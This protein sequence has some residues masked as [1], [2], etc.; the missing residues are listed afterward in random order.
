MYSGARG[1]SVGAG[2]S[3]GRVGQYHRGRG[4][5]RRDG[6][7]AGCDPVRVAVHPDVPAALR[8]RARRRERRAIR[9]ARAAVLG[10]LQVLLTR[11]L[12]RW[13]FLLL[14]SATLLGALPPPT[15]VLF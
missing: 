6:R 14:F 7:G 11:A 12:N 4:T 2:T 15:R 5:P 3:P 13:D 9:A 1:R 8:Q 10:H